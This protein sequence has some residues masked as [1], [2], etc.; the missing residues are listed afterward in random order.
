MIMTQSDKPLSDILRQISISA[1]QTITHYHSNEPSPFIIICNERRIAFAMYR[2][3]QTLEQNYPFK[4]GRTYQDTHFGNPITYTDTPNLC[5]IIGLIA[6]SLGVETIPQ[7]NVYRPQ[8]AFYDIT[9]EKHTFAIHM[10]FKYLS[11]NKTK[12]ELNNDLIQ[13]NND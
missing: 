8:L 4:K 5:G 1:S 13:T 6:T 10:I 12:P 3:S 11:S 2:P 9:N 7:E